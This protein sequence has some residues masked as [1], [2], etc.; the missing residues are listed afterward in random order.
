MAAKQLPAQITASDRK[1]L[2][3]KED[4][5]KDFAM[6]LVMDSMTADR[7]NSDGRFIRVLVRA[8]QVKNSFYYPFDSVKG[9]S[10]LYAPDSA[11]RIFT[12]NIQIDD[13]YARQRGAIQMKTRDGNLKLFSLWDNSEFTAN[14]IDSVRTKDNWIGAVYYN[15]IKTQFN[16]K[17]Y[18][19]LFGIDYNNV[20]STKKW[21]EVL[22]FN[23]RNE[24]V[25]GGPFFNFSRDSVPIPTQNRYSLEFKKNV[26]VLVNYVD[27]LGMILVDHLISETDEPEKKWTYIPDGDNEAFKW[28]GGKWVHLDKAFTYKLDMR[29]IDLDLGNPPVGDPL[30]DSKGN[31]NDKKLEEKSEK[32]RARE[33]ST[34]KKEL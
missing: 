32:N 12:W 20:M 17:N 14:A 4:T 2:M 22:S 13:Y 3:A 8:L 26:R 28:E 6:N 24:P 7:M 16:A 18:Y 10:V 33:D 9:I 31:R 29:G 34:R 11:F 15:I 25:F 30:I 27:E 19:T 23:E 1:K 21:I 5:L